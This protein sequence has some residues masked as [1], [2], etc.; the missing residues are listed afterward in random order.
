MMKAV[1]VTG[2]QISE[3]LQLTHEGLGYGSAVDGEGML[4]QVGIISKGGK[5][6]TLSISATLYDE[7]CDAWPIDEVNDG[8][9]FPMTQS[10][11]TN[12]ITR[13]I[14]RTLEIHASPHSLA[15]P[16]PH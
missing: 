16:S 9:L 2:C 5:A 7:I 11:A 8:R 13:A 12:R 10:N 15:I 14:W 3:A 4:S 6:I 1:L